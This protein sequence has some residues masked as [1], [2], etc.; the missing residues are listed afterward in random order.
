MRYFREVSVSAGTEKPP[1]ILFIWGR[2]RVLP[3]NIDS[4]SITETEFSAD[5]HPIRARLP[6]T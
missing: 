5:L 2:K 6:L 1:M 3:V 4:M